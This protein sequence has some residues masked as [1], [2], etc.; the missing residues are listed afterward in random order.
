MGAVAIRDGR[1]LLI[2]RGRGV[3]VGSWSLP[4]GR[5][6]FGELLEEACVRE[7]REETGLHGRVTGLCGIAQRVGTG[8]HYVIVD[9]WVDIDDGEAVAGDDAD[10]VVWADR[11]TLDQLDLVPRLLEFLTEFGVLPRLTAGTAG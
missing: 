1:L 5:V 9:Y 10:D 3:A 8:H 11:A 7:L 6:G 4:G 2:K